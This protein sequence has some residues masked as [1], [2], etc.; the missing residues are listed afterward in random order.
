MSDLVH[1]AETVKTDQ[2]DVDT[3]TKSG[4]GSETPLPAETPK[5]DPNISDSV[6]PEKNVVPEVD[7]S[8][9]QPIA[10]TATEKET[11]TKAHVEPDVAT[12]KASSETSVEDTESKS[13]KREDPEKETVNQ[14][15][16][17]STEVDDD[18]QSKENDHT[19]P[20]IEE[21]EED[22]EE[23]VSEKSV[24][25]EKTD[26]MVDVETYKTTKVT[27]KAVDGMAKRLTSN[28]GKVVQATPIPK[29]APAGKK[30]SKPTVKKES[31]K[32]KEISSSDSEYD[33]E[34][35]VQNIIPPAPKFK[36]AVKKVIQDVED[37]PC[38]SV[39]F[40]LASYALRW[41]YI[42][43][44]RLALT[45][46]VLAD[47]AEGEQMDA[48]KEDDDEDADTEVATDDEDE[49]TSTSAEE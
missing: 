8:L 47:D 15:E 12:S 21:E 9:D 46:L 17:Q 34:E 2:P 41:N 27:K 44:R 31:L 35:D 22:P 10:D 11:V 38:D 37:A 36:S 23:N 4:A 42:Y 6:D 45:I 33:V 5:S 1:G 18:S 16:N 30:S 14:G 40:H 7:T 26:V 13:N 32:R 20:L 28:V 19:E 24:P 43:Q 39:S 49:A 25:V 29:K 3:S 48:D